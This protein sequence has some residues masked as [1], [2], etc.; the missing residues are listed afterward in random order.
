MAFN[1]GKKVRIIHNFHSFFLLFSILILMIYIH[2]SQPVIL[3]FSSSSCIFSDH[4]CSQIY[5]QSWILSSR[6]RE[7]TS[8]SSLLSLYILRHVASLAVIFA[9]FMTLIR[10]SFFPISKNFFYETRLLTLHFTRHS[11]LALYLGRKHKHA[12]FT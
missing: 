1:G 9:I 4:H 6:S 10:R 8:R 7:E 3:F 12:I 11:H 2:F 5:V